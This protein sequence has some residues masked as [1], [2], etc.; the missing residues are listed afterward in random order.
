MAA[1]R[2]L[3]LQERRR[4]KKIIL[5]AL[6]SVTGLA[7]C[8][9]VVYGLW[10]PEVNINSIHVE[11][12]AYANQALIEKMARG[13]LEGTYFF[14]VPRSNAFLYP[15]T[16]LEKD[17]YSL[18]P[19]VKEAQFFRVGLT[20]LSIVVTERA[21]DALWCVSLPKEDS[22]PPCYFM[23][24]TGF[25][26]Y[27]AE[28]ADAPLR[29]YTGGVENEPLKQTFFNGEYARLKDFV[30]DVG[31]ATERT[32]VSV[33]VDEHGDVSIFFTEGGEL[34]FAYKNADDALLENIE[35]VFSSR[36]LNSEEVLEYADFRFGNKIYVKFKED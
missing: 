34:R 5:V 36:K 25:I 28:N 21:P 24:E 12:A 7:L 26:F 31:R 19:A 35:S 17:L 14:L 32:P 13:M 1:S 2:K 3:R 4:R 29:T 18:F 10:R 23:D 15:Q 33:R 20:E 30:D 8:A 27:K 11:G 16:A 6:V 22:I 9:G